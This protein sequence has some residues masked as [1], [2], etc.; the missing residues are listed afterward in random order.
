MRP[1]QRSKHEALRHP[2]YVLAQ[3]AAQ[4]GF[5][6]YEDRAPEYGNP[7]SPGYGGGPWPFDKWQA[8]YNDGYRAGVY[9][10]M[11]AVWTASNWKQATQELLDEVWSMRRVAA[12]WH[13]ATGQ[14]RGYAFQESL[15]LIWGHHVI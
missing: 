9:N 6:A 10:A 8:L 11:R 4:P 14:Y 13:N 1:Y 5:F 15:Y 3:F 7:D 2:D 12:R